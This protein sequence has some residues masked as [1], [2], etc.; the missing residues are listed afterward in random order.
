MSSSLNGLRVVAAVVD[1]WIGVVVVVRGVDD[2][3]K[4]G[5][6]DHRRDGSKG[7]GAVLGQCWAFGGW[8]LTRG[9]FFNLPITS[10]LNS[11]VTSQDPVGSS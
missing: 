4:V 7:S 8:P 11:E 5:G 9:S 2:T 1:A 10:T 3:G 6:A